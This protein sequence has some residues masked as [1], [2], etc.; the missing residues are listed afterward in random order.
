MEGSDLKIRFNGSPVGADLLEKIRTHKAQLVEHLTN[1]GRQSVNVE[2]TSLASQPSYVLS[3]A[4]RRLWVLSQ[5]G[6]ANLAYNMP[7]ALLLEGTLDLAAL[8]TAFT[9]LVSRH[10]ILRTVFRETGGEIRQIIH[11][12]ASTDFSIGY[13]DLSA[14]PTAKPLLRGIVA[15]EALKPFDLTVG[16]LLRANVY[17]LAEQ[18]WLF[19]YTMHHI[20][21]DSW[22]MKV[23]ISEVLREYTATVRQQPLSLPPL[24]I[25]Y[26]D[27]AA[28]QQA[29][30]EGTGLASA[31]AYWL[32]NLAAD[33]PVLSLPGTSKRPALKTYRGK[34][35][36]QD[37]AGDLA[38]TMTA[39]AQEQGCTLLM[40]LLATVNVLLYRYTAQEDI[41][42]GSPVSGREHGSLTDQ[43][44]FYVQLLP[45]RTRFSGQGSFRELLGQ[46]K[47]TTLDA[48]AHQN[49]P[50]DQ[51]I[52]ELQLQRDL[53]RSALFDVLVDFGR[54][55]PEAADLLPAGLTIRDFPA[56]AAAT[57][58]FDL[59]FYFNQSEDGLCVSL[60]YNSD[61]YEDA[62]MARMLKHLQGLM[63]AVVDSPTTPVGTLCYM[64]AAEEKQLRYNFGTA[65][66]DTALSKP[67]LVAFAEQAQAVPQRTAVVCQGR[68]LTYHELDEKTDQVAH[69]LVESAGVKPGDLVGIMLDR[70]EN[71]VLALLGVLKAGG[72][73]VP[74]DVAYPQVR[75]EHIMQEAGI[76]VLFTQTDYL[77]DL[78]QY[79][80]HIFAI[81]SQLELLPPS[82]GIP[83]P[84]SDPDRLS[85][86]IYTSGSTGM[87]KG[88]AITHGN[89]ANYIGWANR[90][91]FPGPE[92]VHFGLYTSLS[93][94]FT[95]TSIFCPL[96]LG[97]TLTVFEQEQDLLAVFRYSFGPTSP[98][99]AIKLTPSHIHI[100]KTLALPPAANMRCAIVGGEAVKEEHVH[101]LKR[102]NPELRIYNE[103]GPTETTVGCVVSELQNNEPILIGKPITNTQAYVLDAN[104]MLCPVGVAG[105]I[106]VGGAGVG[107]GYLHQPQRTVDLFLNDPFTHA[108]KIYKTGDRAK[109]TTDGN[110]VYLGRQEGQVK[111]RGNR[112]E[113]GEIEHLLQAYP[114]VDDCAV[115]AR[116][117]AEGIDE[118]VAYVVST[119][120][121]NTSD[122]RASLAEN[123][124]SYAV[125]GYFVLL[126]RLP[127]TLNGKTD[128]DKLPAPS[129]ARLDTGPAYVAPRNETEQRLVAIWQKVLGKE[130]VGIQDNF[131][132]LGGNSLKI[133]RMATLISQELNR[134]LSVVDL[135]KLPSISTLADYLS[136]G[137]TEDLDKQTADINQANDIM[138]ETLYLLQ[139]DGRSD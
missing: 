45:L 67:V 38:K 40:Y 48:Y 44:G 110:L 99:N 75:K 59:T 13:Q 35:I 68:Q 19:T 3:S 71:V 86:V 137:S 82:T 119:H 115:L 46:V 43:I 23:L 31:R 120:L 14:E 33:V 135:F 63:R 103:Y 11:P 139:D 24:N 133:V 74:I 17:K 88:C 36:R 96:T 87:P 89:L 28:W 55:Q 57:S 25:Q 107:Q 125:P 64:S 94:D 15:A 47:Q 114:H 18:Q 29:Q 105:E 130:Q 7:A 81:D 77:F 1:L 76:G 134:T 97:G 41:V 58:K 93:F 8:T 91:Y 37:V 42:I 72:A 113:V 98:L 10:E 34:T 73:F 80:G 4:Q 32:A 116:S 83:L 117:N 49:F 106:Y 66:T 90:H 123:L 132:D 22:S 21:S 12:P 5:F 108:G 127:L 122:L 92:P 2:I 131:F 6:D 101:V 85:Y 100:L 112:I 53:S 50:F 30:L 70:S 39:A 95:L 60:E 52:D 121:L 84:N 78:D 26:K 136:V 111:I 51:L 9:R 62:L 65:S 27:Y 128:V 56:E 126:D 124:P 61:V 138:T 69:Y 104:Q 129:T 54:Q 102:L 20:V 109:W 118:L 79:Q 16:P